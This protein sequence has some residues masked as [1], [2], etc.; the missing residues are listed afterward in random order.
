MTTTSTRLERA[1]V[2]T[3][4]DLKQAWTTYRGLHPQTRIRDAAQALGV[5]EAQLLATGCGETVTRLSA[6]EGNFGAMI[7][8]LKALGGVMALT[9]NNE[10]VHERKGAYSRT[11]L[12]PSHKMGQVLDEGIDLR[13]FFTTWAHAFALDAEGK[14]GKRKRSIQFFSAS[15]EAIHKI[16]LQDE[17]DTRAFDDYVARF[18][19][20]DQSPAINVAPA[21]S[22][23][24]ERADEEIDV[25]AF[26]EAWSKLQ[27]THE[28]FG[29]TR[30][31]G[32]TRTQALRLAAPDMAHQVEN[33]SLRRVLEQAA[34]SALPIMVFVGNPGCIQIHSGTVKNIKPL[35]EWLNVLD[36]DF[37][38]HVREDLI[39]SSW[40]VR[41]PT[42]EG[43]MTSLE[44]YNTAGEQ[45]A[46]LFS[47]RKDYKEES[48]KWR[49]LLAALPEVSAR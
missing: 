22:H 40:V 32:V 20:D 49:A 26:R 19:S 41:K 34:E 48:D 43:I 38:L 8:D 10:A 14:N 37:N 2:I 47:K 45:I 16:F 5:S 12:F 13:L 21:P 24:P 44:L 11:E 35:H 25:A 6:P 17:S 33:S 36:A 39:H 46:L 9:R 4:P 1:T 31:F 27:N 18:I 3:P 15:G 7:E 28:F 42:A 30:K 23:E 29:L